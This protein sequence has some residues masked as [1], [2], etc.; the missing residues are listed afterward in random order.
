MKK[1]TEAVSRR[2]FAKAAAFTTAAMLVPSELV[3]QE[4]KPAPEASKPE[5]APETP[6]LSAA[7]QAEADLA[8]EALMRKYGARFSQ[9][10]KK[11]IRRLVTLQ[12]SALDKLRAASVG[13][14]DEPATVFQLY[15]GEVK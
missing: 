8:Y 7:S 6:K 4:Q 3:S 1:E 9:E 5:S 12:Q 15:R 14:V 11:D 13:S 2:V 10:Q